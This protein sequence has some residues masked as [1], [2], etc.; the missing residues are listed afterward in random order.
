MIK[1]EK[2]IYNNIK[3]TYNSDLLDYDAFIPKAGRTNLFNYDSIN[4]IL[5]QNYNNCF[6]IIINIT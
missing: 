6:K 3:T 5:L 2:R 4:N 1:L